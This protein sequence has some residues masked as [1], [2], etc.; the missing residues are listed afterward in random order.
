MS[1][2]R[3]GVGSD[4][5]LRARFELDGSVRELAEADLRTLQV[6]QNAQASAEDL[7]GLA[8]IVIALLVFGM[9]TVAHVQ[10]GDVHT[11]L[12]QLLEPVGG[13]R[14]RAQRANDLGS[15]HRARLVTRPRSRRGALA[16]MR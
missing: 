1:I 7:R 8:D 2:A 13:R 6:G 5:E 11:G 12:D 4:R 10:P 15:A 14:R 3:D 16:L 9:T